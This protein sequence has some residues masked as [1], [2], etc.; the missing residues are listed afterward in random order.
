MTNET[1][2]PVVSNRD[3]LLSISAFPHTNDQGITTYGASLQRAYQKPE[4]KGSQNY[5]RQKINLYPDELLRVAALCVRTY[6]DILIY[7]QMNRQQ[8]TGN[9]PAQSMDTDNAPAPEL[10]D[11]VPF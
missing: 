9:Y 8:S 1:N 10:D 3:K 4:Q 6:N 7:A 5:E 2:K 11:T